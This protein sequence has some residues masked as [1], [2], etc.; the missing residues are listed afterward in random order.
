MSTK[1]FLITLISL[2]LFISSDSVPGAYE[3]IMNEEIDYSI[4]LEDERMIPISWSNFDISF[5]ETIQKV[6]VFVSTKRNYLGKWS[7]AFGTSTTVKPEY[8]TMTEDMAQSF[9]KKTGA[10]VWNVDEKTA[11]II[12]MLFEGNLKFGVWWFDC[13]D[14]LIEKVVVFTSLYKGGYPWEEPKEEKAKEISPGVYK[15]NVG[16]AYLYKKLGADKMLPINWSQFDM[17]KNTTHIITKIDVTI[18]TSAE[19]LGKWQG[20]FGSSTGQIPEYWLMTEDME[21]FFDSKEGTLTWDIDEESA[22]AIQSQTDG[23]IKFG[24]W[25]VDSQEFV[26]ETCTVYTKPK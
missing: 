19:K 14:F 9:T 12:Q 11:S 16:D 6:V 17:I 24:V 8:W 25:W 5:E 22:K 15:A 18:S 3:Y 1:A 2:F 21:Q 26:I 4:L 7:G 10:I 20:A 23:Q 13:N